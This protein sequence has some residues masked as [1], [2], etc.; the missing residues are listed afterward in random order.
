MGP[1]MVHKRDGLT[2]DTVGD[3]LGMYAKACNNIYKL[4]DMQNTIAI[5]YIKKSNTR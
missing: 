5:L 3:T 2:L 1:S 4:V